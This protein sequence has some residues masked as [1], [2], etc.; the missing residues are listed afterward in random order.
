MAELPEALAQQQ[1]AL[2]Y[3]PVIGLNGPHE[4]VTIAAQALARWQ[5]PRFS[6]IGPEEFVPRAEQSSNS[7]Q[8]LTRWVLDEALQS[9]GAR[10]AP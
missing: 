3:Q 4:G 2:H 9:G 1:L 8:L 7:M 6:L 5:H 10:R